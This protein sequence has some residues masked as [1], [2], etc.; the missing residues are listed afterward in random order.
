MNIE[1]NTEM[2][3]VL[4]TGAA[5]LI[6]DAL[7]ESEALGFVHDGTPSRLVVRAMEN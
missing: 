6:D 1:T 7:T 3:R 4:V 2:K 5:G